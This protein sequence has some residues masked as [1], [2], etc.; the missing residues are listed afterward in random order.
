MDIENGF[1]DSDLDDLDDDGNRTGPS[2]AD[3]LRRL[4]RRD[5]DDNDTVAGDGV[6]GPGNGSGDRVDA[7]THDADD[8]AA[9]AAPVMQPMEDDSMLLWPGFFQGTG[10]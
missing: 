6:D 9:A 10:H 8:A 5:F 1:G 4:P 2:G 7:L 3:R